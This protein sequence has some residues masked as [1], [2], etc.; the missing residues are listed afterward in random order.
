[1]HRPALS[2]VIP[3]YNEEG[4]LETLHA[5]VGAA[6]RAAVGGDSEIVLV[7]DGSRDASWPAMQR[8]AAGDPHLVAINLSPNPGHQLALTAGRDLCTRDPRLVTDADPT[9]PTQPN[10]HT[11]S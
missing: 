8:L 1:M 10:R 6:A 3:C 11:H 5:R 4:C 2:I 9:H 7:N